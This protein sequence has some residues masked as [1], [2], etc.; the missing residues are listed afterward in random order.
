MTHI[1]K[2]CLF[3]FLFFFSFP[4]IYA[5]ANWEAEFTLG[6]SVYQG[7]VPS[8]NINPNQTLNSTK[9][10][11]RYNFSPAW[12]ASGNISHV[13][14]DV[15]DLNNSTFLK[16]RITECNILVEWFPFRGYGKNKINFLQPYLIYR[17]WCRFFF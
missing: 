7:D 17:Y 12:S 3:S 10:G 16:N 6:K 15:F 4:N 5:Q 8:T 9:L 14:L 11:L 2:F 13:T 1:F